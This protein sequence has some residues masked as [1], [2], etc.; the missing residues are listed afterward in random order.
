MMKIKSLNFFL[1]LLQMMTHVDIDLSSLKYKRLSDPFEM[2]SLDFNEPSDGEIPSFLEQ[3]SQQRITACD[4]GQVTAVVYWFELDLTENVRL[5]TLEPTRHWR[6]AAVMQRCHLDVSTG[7][8]LLIT[9]ACKNS[10]VDVTV[11]AY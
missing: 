4:F 1:F 6:Q 10:Y 11:K 2:F 3:T 8:E 7:T 5:C 9:A